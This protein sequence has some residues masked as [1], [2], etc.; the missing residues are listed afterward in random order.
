MYNNHNLLSFNRRKNMY[1]ILSAI[2]QNAAVVDTKIG[3]GYTW[4][5]AW[6][7]AMC[8]IVI[9]FLMLVLLVVVIMLFGKVMRIAKNTTETAKIE[10]K[11][12]QVVRNADITDNTD[13]DVVAAIAAAVGYL[14]S[15]TGIKPV[16]R[17]IKCSDKKLGRS[18]WANAG[19]AQN[20][21]A[22]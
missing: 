19:I 10:V 6:N 20:T 13:E 11:P 21:R 1:S 9:V 2:Q 5:D 14:Y 3:E 18:A 12:A 22:F 16:I 4:S 15:G 8:G 7:V 17:A